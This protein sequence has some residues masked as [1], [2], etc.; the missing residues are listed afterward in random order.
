MSDSSASLHRRRPMTG[1]DPH[2]QNR[3]STPLEL[4]F[5][6]TFVVAF[7]TAASSLS[8]ALSEEHIGSGIVAFALAAFAVTWAW[9]NYSWL[10]SA[11]DTDDAFFRIATLVIMVG[12]LIVALGIL[13]LVGAVAFGWQQDRAAP[14]FVAPAQTQRPQPEPAQPVDGSIDGV[15]GGVS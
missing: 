3:V 2:E 10:A 11:Y 7:G 9:I 4:L 8:H 6:L 14:Q 1:R 13:V 15:H 12:V 5:D